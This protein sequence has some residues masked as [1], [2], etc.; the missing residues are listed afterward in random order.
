MP[1]PIGRT[2]LKFPSQEILTNHV[3]QHTSIAP[4]ALSSLGDEKT[5]QS[6]MEVVTRHFANKTVHEK[7]L[8]L[9]L[10]NVIEQLDQDVQEDV[11]IYGLSKGLLEWIYGK[12]I[13]CVSE[14]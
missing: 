10:K 7:N 14:F 3:L 2:I 11:L 9:E 4:A 5:R 12:E 8:E 6:V 1:N 13:S